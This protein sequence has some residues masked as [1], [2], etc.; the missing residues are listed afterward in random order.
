[1]PQWINTE[2]SRPSAELL[3]QFE[4]IPTSILSDCMNRF[5]AMDAGIKP[6]REGTKLLGAAFTVQAMESSNWEAHQA[7]AMAMAGD[8]LVIAARGGMNNA[9]WGHVMTFAAKQ[10]GLA[11]VVI[12]GCIRDGAENKADTLPIYCRGI[13][14]AGPHKGWQ[15]NINVPVACAGVVVNAGDIIIGDDD[16]IVVIP[17]AKAEE[18]LA[19]AKERMAGEAAWYKRLEA[20][21][22]T[23]EILGLKKPSV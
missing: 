1:M 6:L 9:V 17:L 2:F 12:D 3:K 8:V 5:Q 11:G 23:V 14:S 18:V 20:G 7:L 4:G 22:T 19:E 16:G 21:E 13:A 10:R 15:G